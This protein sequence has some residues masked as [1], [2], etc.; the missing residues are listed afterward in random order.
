MNIP[1]ALIATLGFV[2]PVAAAE[3]PWQ[4]VAPDV[5]IRLIS[6][7]V[8]SASGTTMMALEID[9][10]QATKTYWRVPGETGL[11]LDIDLSA[12][13]GVG[14]YH[15]HWPYPVREHKGG[16]LDFVYYGRTVLPFEVDV[17]DA[18]GSIRLAAT[19]GV[20]SDVCIP[21]QASFSLPLVD[22]APDRPSSLRI[23]QA[24]AQVPIDW[25]D[26]AEPVGGATVQPELG[27]LAVEVDT[28]AIDVE[29]LI[30]AT[31]DGQPIFGVPQKSPQPGLVLLPIL[32]KS[33][34]SALDGQAVELTFLTE[35]GA[36]VVDRTIE[37]G[38]DEVDEAV[39]DE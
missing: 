29:S 30:A 3:T 19:L 21:A 11:P 12:S 24:L 5:S 34:N 14:A 16:Y 28:E 38:S 9:M 37:F 32:G 23:K 4:H 18:S 17:V 8:V 7:G 13:T 1:A 36:Y 27:A 22:V 35:K 33:D 20:C 10:P 39:G 31:E 2:V 25:D 26:G 15:T 6:S